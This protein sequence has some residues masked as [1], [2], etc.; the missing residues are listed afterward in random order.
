MIKLTLLLSLL[1][2][3]GCGGIEQDSNQP[4]NTLSPT[5]TPDL[6][7]TV[8]ASVRMILDEHSHSYTAI[9]PDAAAHR[10]AATDRYAPANC[11][12]ATGAYAP[13]DGHPGADCSRE[14]DGDALAILSTGY[15]TG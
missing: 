6:V 8:D 7:A 15:R 12:A 11:Y 3:L 14:A 13:T 5:A 10:Y 2:V 9:Y 1:L 4:V